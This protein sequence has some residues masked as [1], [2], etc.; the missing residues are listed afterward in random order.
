V[1]GSGG[2]ASSNAGAGPFAAVIMVSA[3]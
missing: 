3:S 1:A 2:F